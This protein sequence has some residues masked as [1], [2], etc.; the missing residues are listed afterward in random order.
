MPKD[1]TI[2]VRVPPEMKNKLQAIADFEMRSL[3]NLIVKILNDY[4]ES[5][6]D[7]STTEKKTQK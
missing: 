3:S 1:N 7:L 4:L 6:I 5:Q 2:A